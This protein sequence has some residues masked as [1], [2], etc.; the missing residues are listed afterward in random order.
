QAIQL[1]KAFE[2]ATD[3]YMPQPYPGKITL[4]LASE[5]RINNSPT[6][7]EL[8]EKGLEI[9]EIPGYHL[10]MFK[11]PN[12]KVLTEKLKACLETVQTDNS[13]TNIKANK[14]V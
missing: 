8:A 12:V 1:I 11:E 9:H 3:N 5:L 10:S 4:F 2:Q 7:E 14:G 6:L 13:K